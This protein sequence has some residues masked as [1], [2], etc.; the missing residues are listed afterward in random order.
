M[1]KSS[2]GNNGS[3]DGKLKALEDAIGQIEKRFGKGAILRMGQSGGCMAVEV[4]PSGS[5]SLDLA[6]GVGGIPKG[7]VT[8]IFGPE[9]SGKSTLAHHIIAEAQKSGG[10]A[11]YI[12]EEHSFDPIYAA[13]CGVKIDDLF[14]SQP[15]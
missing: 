8:E 4:I 5:L 1:V 14:M 12:A 2:T 6:L 10:I 15:D 3:G 9:S 13:N 7:R 11:V